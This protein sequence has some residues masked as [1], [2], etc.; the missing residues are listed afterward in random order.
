[1]L[2][3]IVQTTYYFKNSLTGLINAALAAPLLLAAAKQGL[4]ASSFTPNVG[5]VEGDFTEAAFTGYAQSATIVWGAPLN[6]PD[7]SQTSLSPANLFRCTTTGTAETI[8]GGFVSDGVASPGSG[9]LGSYVMPVPIPIVNA[10]DGFSVVI[11]WPMG[12]APSDCEAVITS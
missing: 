7:G 9:I 4:A 10:G 12:Q 5:T 11:A 1:M 2:A 6:E 8:Y 3:P